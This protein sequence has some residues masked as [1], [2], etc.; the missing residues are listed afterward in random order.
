MRTNDREILEI[1]AQYNLILITRDV[2]TIT[3]ILTEMMIDEIDFNG[4]IFVT[5]SAFPPNDYGRLIN[6]LVHEYD[7]DY[8]W[9]NRTTY[10]KPLDI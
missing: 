10:L 3:E 1:A 7:D 8:V 2:T 6:A 5:H 9:I 4:V